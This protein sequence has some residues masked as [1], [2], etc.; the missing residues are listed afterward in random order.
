MGKKNSNNA[1]NNTI[2]NNKANNNANNANRSQILIRQDFIKS[3]SVNKVINDDRTNNQKNVGANQTVN[4]KPSNI[5]TPQK[6]QSKSE[7]E[8]MRMDTST[9]VEQSTNK[10]RP[11]DEPDDSTIEKTPCKMNEMKLDS[12]PLSLPNPEIDGKEISGVTDEH[13]SFSQPNLEGDSKEIS[14]A[15]DEQ[16]SQKPSN[17]ST[18]NKSVTDKNTTRT[19]RLKYEKFQNYHV[20]PFNMYVQNKDKSFRKIDP[21]LINKY[22]IEKFRNEKILFRARSISDNK[23]HIST[24]NR[25]VANQVLMDPEWEKRGLEVFI[26]NHLMVKQGVIKGVST[27][28]SIHDIKENL[29]VHSYWNKLEIIDVRRFTKRIQNSKTGK[30]EE[31]DLPIIQFTVLGQELPAKAFIYNVEKAV[32]KYYPQIRQCYRCLHFGHLKANCKAPNERCMRCGEISQEQH[33][34]E[35]DPRLPIC[36]HCKQ[37]HKAIDKSC[38]RRQREQEIKNKATDEGISVAEMK[39]IIR[40]NNRRYTPN[41]LEFP[42]LRQTTGMENTVNSN[43]FQNAP[44]PS[45]A[46]KAGG[47]AKAQNHQNIPHNRPPKPSNIPL[48]QTAKDFFYSGSSFILNSSQKNRDDASQTQK[49]SQLRQSHK[50]ALLCP[51]GRTEATEKSSNIFNFM[52]NNNETIQEDE[53]EDNIKLIKSTVLNRTSFEKLLQAVTFMYNQMMIKSQA[54]IRNSQT[55]QA[56]TPSMDDLACGYQD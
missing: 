48:R 40:S 25:A 12:F 39:K 4:I 15:S 34:C 11:L 50:E 47:V 51:N 44:P 42:P 8:D 14:G 6:Y 20:G 2:V 16:H 46:H 3:P 36:F 37:N 24:I 1:N 19:S 41:P 38:P 31:I 23:V 45:Y 18:D 33:Q 22:L 17:S 49:L 55:S 21:I 13:S 5:N 10:K 26:P 30:T 56:R 43:H 9:P 32:E 53:I 29:E 35:N 7:D 28:I 52:R 54:Q 27:E